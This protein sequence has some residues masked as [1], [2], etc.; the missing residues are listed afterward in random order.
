M[1][2]TLPRRK[3]IRL[4][5]YDY[6]QAGLYFITVCVQDRLCLFGNVQ[7][8]EMTLNDAGRMV[9]RWYDE[10]ER[11]YPDK[12]CHNMV[13]MPNHFHCIIEIVDNADAIVRATLCECPS[14]D[15]IVR[16]TPCGCPTD[17]HDDT[18]VAH[19]GATLRGRPFNEKTR[20]FNE[21]VE[22]INQTEQSNSEKY[23]IHNVRYGATISDVMDWFKTMTTNEYIRNV[24]ATPCDCPHDWQPFNRKLWQRN[25]YEHIIR[26]PDAY[27]RIAD[28]IDGNSTKWNEDKFH[29]SNF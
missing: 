6:S 2:S 8:G 21:N 5:G 13:V 10:I 25:F 24:R 27:G 29:S 15:A 11:K 9:E 3:N 12:R 7:N 14:T 18:T 26:T 22:P 16:A 19:V 17:A 28:Y 23:G 20:P 4:K 1:S